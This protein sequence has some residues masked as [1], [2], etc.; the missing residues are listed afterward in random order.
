MTR[1]LKKLEWPF[2]RGDSK[3]YPVSLPASVYSAGASL[4]FA[5]KTAIDDDPLDTEAVV[6]KELTDANITESGLQVVK[7]RLAFAP[8]DTTNLVPA[9]YLAEFQFVSADKN[10]VLTFPDPNRAVCV[11]ALAGDVNRRTD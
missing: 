10:T 9:D 4:F 2:T 8:A 11:F 6:R 7:W 5:V 1:P 3:I